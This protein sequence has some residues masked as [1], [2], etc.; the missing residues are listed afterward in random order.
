MFPEH[1]EG[2]RLVR[3]TVAVG[4]EEVGIA[5]QGVSADARLLVEQGDFEALVRADRGTDV[6][7]QRLARLGQPPERDRARD[8]RDD[9]E[10]RGEARAG[11]ERPAEGLAG[12]VAL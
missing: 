12:V 11:G 3:E 2:S 8:D 7:E 5:G 10:Q 9:E 6:V 1:R 4:G